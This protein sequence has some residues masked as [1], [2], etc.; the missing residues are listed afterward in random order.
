MCCMCEYSANGGVSYTGVAVC[1]V[2][3]S[4]VLTVACLT[5]VLL[6]VLSL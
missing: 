3:V 1:V 4:A 5:Q 2:C 6:C